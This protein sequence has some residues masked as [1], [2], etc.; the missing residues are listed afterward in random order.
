MPEKA[1]FGVIHSTSME[2]FQIC[3][4]LVSP[5][6]FL[7][8]DTCG[9]SIFPS[10]GTEPLRAGRPWFPFRQG[11]A[12]PLLLSTS[13]HQR[14][15]AALGTRR[16]SLQPDGRGRLPRAPTSTTRGRGTDKPWNSA[17]S[18]LLRCSVGFPGVS[19]PCRS[20]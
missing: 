17:H 7:K 12:A 4:V 3:P 8:P 14:M 10:V 9:H 13:P 11:W 20:L 1:G 16:Q 6:L 19:S 18:R 15:E 2:R 5:F